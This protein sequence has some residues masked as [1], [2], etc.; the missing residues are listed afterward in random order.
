MSI[1]AIMTAYIRAYHSI[2][3]NPVI[4]SDS[5]ALQ[6]IPDER[7]ILIEQG[8]ATSWCDHVSVSR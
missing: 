2:N 7:R 8:L 4:F 3:D 6:L 1:T 5:L